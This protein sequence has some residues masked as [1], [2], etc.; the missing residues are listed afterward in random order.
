GLNAAYGPTAVLHGI[1]I[2]VEERGI[3]TLLGANGAGKTTMLRAICRMMV[4][5]S[6]GPLRRRAHRR[7]GDGGHRP[8]RHRARA[9]WPRHLRRADRRGESAARRLYKAR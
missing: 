6:G 3:V 7:Q 5:I 8:A 2:A 4:R 1:D 9:G